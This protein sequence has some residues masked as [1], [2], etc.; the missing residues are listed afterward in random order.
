M[1][2]GRRQGEK[3]KRGSQ[4]DKSKNAGSDAQAVASHNLR[5]LT[6]HNHPSPSLP[7]AYSPTEVAPCLGL[8]VAHE[9]ER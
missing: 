5:A 2:V 7:H 6:N 3:E 4:E 9:A 1:S 8:S